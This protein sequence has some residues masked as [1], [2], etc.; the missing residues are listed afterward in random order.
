MI[1]DRKET[2]L[3]NRAIVQVNVQWKN[4]GEDEATWELEDSMR[5]VYPFFFL[6]KIVYIV[7]KKM[8]E[9]VSLRGRGV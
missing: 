2:L 6:Y 9:N 5:M 1:L 7:F 3:R 8:S 4:F